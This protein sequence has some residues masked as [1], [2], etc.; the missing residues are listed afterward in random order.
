MQPA[1]RSEMVD[2]VGWTSSLVLLLTIG[3]QIQKQLREHTSRGVSHWL[4]IGQMAASG[5]FVA[6]SWLLHNR[7]FVVTNA[8]MFLSAVVG[9]GVLVR[10]RRRTS[11]GRAERAA[12]DGRERC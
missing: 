10:H 2:V 8:L 9:L 12:S 3:S 6:Y 11:H 1:S 5:G 7:V 4:F